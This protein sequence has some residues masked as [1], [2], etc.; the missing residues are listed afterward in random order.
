[1]L[2]YLRIKNLAVVDDMALELASGLTVFTGE[3]GA[4]KSMIL[5]GLGLAPGERWWKRRL[6]RRATNSSPTSSVLQDWRPTMARS[7]C[8]V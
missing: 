6:R 2:A 8:A 5:G 1:M 7:W 4:G 3:T